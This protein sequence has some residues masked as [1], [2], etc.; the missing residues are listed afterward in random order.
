MVPR[1]GR[2]DPRMIDLARFALGALV[3][4]ACVVAIVDLVT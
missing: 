3:V 4:I 2:S 1:G